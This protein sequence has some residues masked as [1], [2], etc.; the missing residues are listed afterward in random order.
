METY[1]KVIGPDSSLVFSTAGDLLGYLN[2]S[3]GVR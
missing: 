2:D 1:R 3:K